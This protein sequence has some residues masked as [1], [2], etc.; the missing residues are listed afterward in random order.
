MQ[1]GR[2]GLREERALAKVEW[3]KEQEKVITTRG[4]NLLVSAA[5]G[6][7]KTA[8]LVERIIRMITDK[9]A[10]VDIDQLLVMTF[11]NAA[12]AEMRERIGAALE[13][14]LE[15]DPENENLERQSTLIHHAKITTIDSFCLRLLREHFN[16][17]DMDPGF[18]IADEGEL[19][20]LQADVMKELLEEYYGRNDDRFFRFVDAYASGKADSG[21]DEYILR[22]W[23]FSQSNPWPGEWIA[24]CRDELRKEDADRP[25]SFDKTEWMQYLMQDAKRQAA[26]YAKQIE[27]AIELANE[28]DGPE[29]YLSMLL[30][31]LAQL[32]RL[33]A[34]T[35][36][37]ELHKNLS[38]LTFGRLA[39]VR[40]KQVQPEKKERA[41]AI[42]NRVK[43]GIKAMISLYAPGD[44]EILFSDMISCREP[45]FML[46][47]LTEE[48][49]ARFQ[50][51]K[52]EK[53]LVDFNDLEHFA[54]EILTGGSKDHRPGP[55]AD[56]LAKSF[57]EIL[58]DEYQDS[59]D[60][61]ETLIRLLSGERFGRPN[62]FMVGDVK[63]SIYKFRLAKPELFLEKYETYGLEGSTCQK[64]E[65]DR[66][67]RSRPEV[68]RSVNDF[69]FALM[70][71]ELGDIS[72]TEETALHAGAAY[73]ETERPGEAM[74]ELLLLHTGDGELLSMDE[75]QADCT[76]KEA[77]ARLIAARIR[78]LT[79]P[80]KGMKI[81]NGKAG[82][83]ET[84]RRGDIVI[85]LRSLSGWAEEF[86]SVLGAEGIPAAAESRTGYFST[87]EVETILNMLAL[88]DNPMQDIPLAGVL[89]SPIG[90]LSDREL[91]LLAAKYK[92][93]AEKG[94]DSGLYGA[95]C[96][97]LE[98]VETEDTSN[99]PA[100]TEKLCRFRS[101]LSVLRKEA[102]YLSVYRLLYR[103][104][105]LT[106]YYEYVSAMPA[107]KLR[108]ANLDML[109]E[110]AAAFEKTSYQ[111]LFDFI[112]YIEKLKKYNTDFGEASRGG[113]NE[114]IVR[115]M[116]IHKSKG[117]EFPV[118]ILA[119]SG[120]QFNRQDSRGKI[121][122]DEKLGAATDFFDPKLK[123]KA[124]TL[125]KNVLSRRMNLENMG[126][127]L[128]I[129]YV[130]MTRAKE[131]LIITAGD[132]YLE[133]RLEKWQGAF[134]SG[135]LPFTVLSSANSY[136]DWIL[137]AAGMASD[138]V[139]VHQIPAGQLIAAK[140]EKQSEKGDLYRRLEALR[141][142]AAMKNA[143]GDAEST[144]ALNRMSRYSYP[145]QE[146]VE[147]HAKLSVSEIK[148]RGQYTDDGECDFLP[149]IPEFMRKE[150]TEDGHEKV[151]YAGGPRPNAGAVRGTIYHHVLELIS[152]AEA[153]SLQDV[154]R[155]LLNMK[156]EGQIEEGEFNTVDAGR[157]WDFFCSPIAVRMREADKKGQLYREKQFAIGIPA[158]LMDE[159]DS[160]ELVL[161]Q[162]IIDAWFEEEDGI[163]LV[164]YKTDRILKGEEKVLLDRYRVQ[165]IYYRHALEQIT[166]KRV[167]E[168]FLYSLT[169]QKQI[170][171][172]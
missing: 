22:M 27:E 11:T 41:A 87:I 94:Q 39:A 168:A 75:D 59:N 131:K 103:V 158:R 125:K 90:G 43:D 16:E 144:E 110:K 150:N 70:T 171:V 20:L 122:I 7:G 63:Q 34:A 154:Q 102:E 40:G 130:A 10:P 80:E 149:T 167:K 29:A 30:E 26:E 47:E 38:A 160:D 162:G 61:Q 54:L 3:T 128:R 127:E 138:S 126:E 65:L 98:C 164:D 25:E 76:S 66:N 84:L 24:R 146:D 119:G 108:Q 4:K 166:K 53:N 159:A 169:L 140:A 2:A 56:E 58:V 37:R 142:E 115:I 112:R 35:D 152:F 134:E 129:L 69:F 96:H 148:H 68:L 5:A 81:W 12:A 153:E 51:R 78:E 71:K 113:E 121:L 1:P 46:L 55:V 77:E 82:Q 15:A 118:V 161:V 97:W 23:R 139:S 92:G 147:L 157:L 36:Y 132:R 89:R 49:T 155:L 33:E 104:Y 117:L 85:L 145:Y 135:Q 21:L 44:M 73:P 170:P 163:V 101:I 172:F 106:G 74:T 156:E 13:E 64:I 111:S 28:A 91:A 100:I 95:F 107:G 42:R 6:S 141:T 32:R 151:R 14:R 93:W 31:D 137:M 48:F 165:M 8:V 133:N 124:P 86:L 57:E 60:V 67:F 120:K 83:Y 9:D 72:Y 18:R 105:E 123:L 45:I 79:D 109:A 116:S 62:V 99:F 50:E 19:L 136:L 143:S 17:L 52:E 114:D 88:V